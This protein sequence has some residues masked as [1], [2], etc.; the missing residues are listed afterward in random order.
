MIILHI[1]GLVWAAIFI[2][3]VLAVLGGATVAAVHDWRER[4]RKQRGDVDRA[5]EI[6]RALF[7]DDAATGDFNAWERSL[8]RRARGY[9][10]GRV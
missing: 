9:A 1:A 3:A 7:P 8:P 6:G 10:R 4:R 2:A 5:R